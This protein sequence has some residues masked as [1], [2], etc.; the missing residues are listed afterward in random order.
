MSDYAYF[1]LQMKFQE[2]GACTLKLPV[3]KLLLALCVGVV[4]LYKLSPLS[5][6][7]NA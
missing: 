2:T 4:A 7:K 3:P 1:P 6:V 5:I